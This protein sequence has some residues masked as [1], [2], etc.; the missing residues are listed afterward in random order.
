MIISTQNNK[1]IWRN[2]ILVSPARLQGRGKFFFPHHFTSNSLGSALIYI[3]RDQIQTLDLINCILNPSDNLVDELPR[4]H[5]YRIRVHAAR[6]GSGNFWLLAV[7][8]QVIIT[9]HWFDLFPPNFPC[10]MKDQHLHTSHYCLLLVKT[11]TSHNSQYTTK[12]KKVVLTNNLN[13]D[14]CS[15]AALAAASAIVLG[16]SH[17]CM[18]F[19]LY[20]A[21]L[22][23]HE[24]Y[25]FH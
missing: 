19:A 18:G 15:T 12:P 10:V 5:T 4:W 8:H 6:G 9:H 20:G 1:P 17:M 13:R 25:N 22:W 7:E 24:M 14:G 16:K 3:E 21:L 2:Y 23:T 11:Q